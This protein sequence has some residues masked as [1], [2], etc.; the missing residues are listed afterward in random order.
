[1]KSIVEEHNLNSCKSL[2]SSFR[3]TRQRRGHESLKLHIKRS[4]SVKEGN[5]KSENCN[6]SQNERLKNINSKS[7]PSCSTINRSMSMSDERQ[8][9]RKQLRKQDSI[10]ILP[11]ISTTNV[12]NIIN[13][14]RMLETIEPLEKT[15]S[16][17]PTLLFRGRSFVMDSTKSS[18]KFRE[19]S[20]ERPPMCQKTDGTKTEVL[21][22]VKSRTSMSLKNIIPKREKSSNELVVKPFF[23]GSHSDQED[24]LSDGESSH[25]NHLYS[26]NRNTNS[27]DRSNSSYLRNFRRNDNDQSEVM[28]TTSSSG[29][30]TPTS[31]VRQRKFSVF[32]VGRALGNL[33]SKGSLP[34][35]PK[36]TANLYDKFGSLKKTIKKRSV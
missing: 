30:S 9:C 23:R 29:C 26:L 27:L 2:H 28:T 32:G 17:K 11:E 4:E 16:N 21:G 19:L 5:S 33:L 31:A 14:N 3:Q 12:E 36:A 13:K 7:P 22:L 15:T 35:L 34:D 10:F 8:K 6:L 20:L 1:M 24:I 25:S 18:M